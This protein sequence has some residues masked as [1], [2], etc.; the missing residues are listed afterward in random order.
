MCRWLYKW[1]VSTCYSPIVYG[2]GK[3]TE[4]VMDKRNEVL[5]KD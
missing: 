3:D 1:L 5:K 2:G 4:D